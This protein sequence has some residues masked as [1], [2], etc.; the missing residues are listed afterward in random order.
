[1]ASIGPGPKEESFLVAALTFAVIIITAVSAEFSLGSIVRYDTCLLNHNT[2][3]AFH[4][5]GC[6]FVTH[7]VSDQ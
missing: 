4:R 1:M 5:L 6:V 3:L 2:H 7:S